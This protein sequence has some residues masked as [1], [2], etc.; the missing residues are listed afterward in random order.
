MASNLSGG[1][2][3]SRRRDDSRRRASWEAGSG[4]E[5]PR[6][7]IRAATERSGRPQAKP[8]AGS[9]ARSSTD[10]SLWENT[11]RVCG[12]EAVA[13]SRRQSRVVGIARLRPRSTATSRGR[14]APA[15]SALAKLFDQR[16]PPLRLRPDPT[17]LVPPQYLPSLQRRCRR[18]HRRQLRETRRSISV[19][20]RAVGKS[21]KV[22]A[23][24][25]DPLGFHQN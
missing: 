7:F 25:C 22:A 11:F 5:P 6:R 9:A 23:E 8:Q 2:E 24:K 17:A 19:Y 13:Q 16:L 12:G 20:H 21:A 3:R 4:A 1:G 14:S 18:F 15:Q 10:G